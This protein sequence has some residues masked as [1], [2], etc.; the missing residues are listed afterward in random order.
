MLSISG[1]SKPSVLSEISK[2]SV[3]LILLWG[4]NSW[5]GVTTLIPY[6]PYVRGQLMK[7]DG[8]TNRNEHAGD[9][10]NFTPARTFQGLETTHFSESDW[11][12]LFGTLRQRSH[13][14]KQ[15]GSLTSQ[16]DS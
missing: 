3:L 13:R 8:L 4:P 15:Q 14:D 6:G 10:L 9:L 7:P 5:K 12:G 11:K 2:F 1:L 16:Q